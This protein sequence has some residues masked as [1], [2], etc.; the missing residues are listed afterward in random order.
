MCFSAPKDELGFPLSCNGIASYWLHTAAQGV[1]GKEGEG[2]I[3]Q[4]QNKQRLRL[5]RPCRTASQ[6]GQRGHRHLAGGRNAGPQPHP[7]A[8]EETPNIKIFNDARV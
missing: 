1:E 7:R 4:Y 5:A 6:G 2:L 3:Y 8:S